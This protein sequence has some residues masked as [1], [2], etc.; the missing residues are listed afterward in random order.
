MSASVDRELAGAR[1]VAAHQRR[2]GVC[3]RRRRG[4]ADRGDVRR[5]RPRRRG[6]VHHAPAR[7]AAHRRD[8][9]G[10]DRERLA[11]ELARREPAAAEVH[12]FDQRI[13]RHEQGAA[14]A[15]CDDGAIIAGPEQHAAAAGRQGRQQAR[16]QAE[17]ADRARARGPTIARPA[18]A[19]ATDGASL[20]LV[21]VGGAGERIPRRRRRRRAA[22]RCSMRP[23]AISLI[24]PLA[25]RSRKSWR[26]MPCGRTADAPAAPSM[27]RGR[28]SAAITCRRLRAPLLQRARDQLGG[29]VRLRLED[30]RRRAAVRGAVGGDEVLRRATRDCWRRS[31]RRRPR[32]RGRRTPGRARAG[33]FQPLLPSSDDAG[34]ACR[35]WVASGMAPSAK[36]GM[37]TA[38]RP[39]SLIHLSTLSSSTEN[40]RWCGS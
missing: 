33:S 12:A 27:V 9:A 11:A 16:Q 20:R 23:G 35:N 3:G 5:R 15:A 38:C 2:A 14:A 17:L 10:V 39:S 28:C 19:S 25:M 30:L 21:R 4:R 36:S 7:R 22:A 31:R 40:S 29:V 6:D 18:V 13:D 8:V 37:N 26:W 34:C 1:Q 24:V 32:P